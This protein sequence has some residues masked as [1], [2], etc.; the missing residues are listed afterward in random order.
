MPEVRYVFVAASDKLAIGRTI[1]E[2][3]EQVFV[4]ERTETTSTEEEQIITEGEL[5]QWK[6]ILRGNRA[7]TIDGETPITAQ[8][9]FA[10]VAGASVSDND[11][12]ILSGTDHYGRK[13]W[14]KIP[15][16]PNKTIKSFL[17]NIEK[18]F[19][20][21]VS[22]AVDENGRVLVVSNTE[23]ESQLSL[24]LTPSNEGGGQLS[25]GQIQ[26]INEGKN[27]PRTISQL[28][29][30][31][32]TNYEK[33]ITLM[34]EG[35]EE[36]VAKA[37]SSLKRDLK[38]LEVISERLQTVLNSLSAKINTMEAESDISDKQRNELEALRSDVEELF[39]LVKQTTDRIVSRL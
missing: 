16:S 28:I 37:L 32:N 8:T 4:G 39:K 23:G 27:K 9:T 3:I 38:D 7:N 31:A 35:K 21:M 24:S 19:D 14:G 30:S 18:E 17:V 10:E 34:G 15:I 12:V 20:D 5:P 26:T 33:W 36:E 2:A 13:V 25:F 29:S 22:V 6:Q 1:D 11:T